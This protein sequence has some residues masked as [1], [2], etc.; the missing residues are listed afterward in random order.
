MSNSKPAISS[1]PKTKTGKVSFGKTMIV[2][3]KRYPKAYRSAAAC[4]F[5]AMV[6]DSYP[7]GLVKTKPGG[8]SDKTGL[9]RTKIINVQTTL[10]EMGAIRQYP[11]GSTKPPEQADYIIT[12]AG[13]MDVD[14]LVDDEAPEPAQVEQSNA[15]KAEPTKSREAFATSPAKP[16]EPPPPPKTNLPVDVRFRADK[17]LEPNSRIPDDLWMQVR[18]AYTA[19]ALD[20]LVPLLEKAEEI[21]A[22]R[23]PFA[24]LGDE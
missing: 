16:V 20:A 7:Y 14:A 22:S 10:V 12:V 6:A 24:R 4:V 18:D 21:I 5:T 11:E 8:L 9:G 15:P 17:V 23:M 1:Q 19:K 3:W 2:F 13:G